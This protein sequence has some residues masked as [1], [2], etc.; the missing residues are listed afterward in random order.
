MLLKILLELISPLV[1][2]P[3]SEDFG[4]WEHLLWP[5]TFPSAKTGVLLQTSLRHQL[6]GLS[7]ALIFQ[8]CRMECIHTAKFR[9]GKAEILQRRCKEPA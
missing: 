7:L 6:G 2:A 5:E 8:D 9:V 4:T 1:G 3:C